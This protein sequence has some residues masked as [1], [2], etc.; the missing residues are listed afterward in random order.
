MMNIDKLNNQVDIHVA[1][2]MKCMDCHSSEE[3]HGTGAE[4]VSMKQAGAMNTKCEKCH[5]SVNQT[6]AHT[7]HKDKLECKSCHIRHV[8]SC[9]NCHFETL[10]NDGKRVAIPVSGWIYLMNQNNKVTSANMQSF[11]VKDNKTFIM[12]APQNSHSVMKTGRNC[13]DCHDNETVKKI[14][15]GSVTLTWLENEKV[16]NLKGVIPVVDGVKYNLV[17]QN[18]HDGKWIPIENPSAPLIHYVGFGKPLTKEQLDKLGK[19]VNDN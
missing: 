2:E 13:N 16:Q 5:E 15:K 19:S 3:I 9:T 11:V 7:V 6:K 17:Y 10:V 14:Q 8:N 1:N 4:Y 12:F 18:Y